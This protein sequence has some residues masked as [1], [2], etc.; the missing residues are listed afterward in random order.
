MTVPASEYAK[1]IGK[2]VAKKRKIF[3]VARCNVNTR[4]YTVKENIQKTRKKGY[5]KLWSILEMLQNANPCQQ[6]TCPQKEIT[7]KRFS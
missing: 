4:T 2:A 5:I 3:G 6:C 7:I 1:K